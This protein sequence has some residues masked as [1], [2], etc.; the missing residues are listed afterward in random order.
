V[1]SPD[2]LIPIPE[3]ARLAGKSRSVMYHAVAT[4]QLPC[5]RLGPRHVLIRRADLDTF[6]CQD[7]PT[8]VYLARRSTASCRGQSGQESGSPSGRPTRAGDARARKGRI[9]DDRGPHD[10]P[11]A[12]APS[13]VA[14]NRP[15]ETSTASPLSTS[16]R[17]R[18]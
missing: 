13:E 7:R 4:G 5:M 2:D 18:S 6:R 9:Q 8:G 10:V 17:T 11:A 16:R 1:P 3:A 15:R 14:R 12:E